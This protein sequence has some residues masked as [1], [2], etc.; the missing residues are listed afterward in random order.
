MLRSPNKHETVISVTC[1]VVTWVKPVVSMRVGMGKAVGLSSSGLCLFFTVV[2]NLRWVV[3][4][5]LLLRCL[6]IK[7]CVN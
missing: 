6:F 4:W 3:T 5:P 7:I 2:I 1:I